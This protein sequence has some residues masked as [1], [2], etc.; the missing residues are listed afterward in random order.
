MTRPQPSNMQRP[1]GHNLAKKLVGKLKSSPKFRKKRLD[2]IA[3]TV[4]TYDGRR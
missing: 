1:E 3:R 2:K 4:R